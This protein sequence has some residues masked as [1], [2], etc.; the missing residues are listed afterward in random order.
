M[1]NKTTPI[2]IGKKGIPMKELFWSFLLDKI[3]RSFAPCKTPKDK[4]PKPET[5]FWRFSEENM[6]KKMAKTVI[7]WGILCFLG[8]VNE[9]VK[10]FKRKYLL[11]IKL[12][13]LVFFTFI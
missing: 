9:E 1:P 10:V 8:I 3:L 5:I 13:S 6:T 2:Y 11:K 7:N 4:I 12:I